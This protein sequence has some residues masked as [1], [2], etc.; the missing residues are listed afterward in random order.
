MYT[1]ERPKVVFVK[2]HALRVPSSK[3]LCNPSVVKSLAVAKSEVSE[4]ETKNGSKGKSAEHS[5]CVRVEVVWEVSG[6]PSVVG[7]GEAGTDAGEDSGW[8]S[9]GDL[10]PVLGAEHVQVEMVGVEL[11]KLDSLNLVEHFGVA[12]LHVVFVSDNVFY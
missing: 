4:S 1:L 2:I 6:L 10:V 3:T 11:D 7:I 8:H 12:L 5:H 9:S